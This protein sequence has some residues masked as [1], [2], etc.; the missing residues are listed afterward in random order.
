MW[1]RERPRLALRITV[2]MSFAP[3]SRKLGCVWSEGRGR[4]KEGWGLAEED[5][6]DLE[7]EVVELPVCRRGGQREEN[8]VEV[9]RIE[10]VGYGGFCWW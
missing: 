4:G 3:R 6:V 8:A 10:G 2:W 9:V 1:I 7:A 5:E